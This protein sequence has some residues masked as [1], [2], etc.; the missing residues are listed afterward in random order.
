MLRLR[1]LSTAAALVFA[2]LQPQSLRAAPI[3]A[4]DTPATPFRVNQIT[5]GEQ[6]YPVV[7]R[8]PDGRFVIAWESEVDDRGASDIFAR[9][10]AADG[11]PLGPQFRVNRFRA[12]RQVFPAIAINASGAFVIAWQSNGQD[13]LALNAY[14]QRYAA[15]G[16]PVD[17]EFRVNNGVRDILVKVSV[18]LDDA[19]NA[20]FVWP[21]RDSP[22]PVFGSVRRVNISARVF[23]PSNAVSVAQFSVFESTPSNL[24]LPTVGVDARGDFVVVWQATVRQSVPLDG[25]DGTGAQSGGGIFGRRYTADGRARGAAFQIDTPPPTS[26]GLLRLFAVDQAPTEFSDR[27]ALLVAPGGD[28]V[29]A[30]QRNGFDFAALG[31][32]LRRYGPDGAPRAAETSFGAPLASLRAPVLAGT[33]DGGFIVAAHGAGIVAQRHGAGGAAITAPLRVDVDAAEAVLYP[34]IASDAEGDVVLVW[35]DY[36]QDGESRGIVARVCTLP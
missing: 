18:A 16:T 1:L 27:P 26:S 14:A 8:A 29:V 32:R 36:A 3:A 6:R 13:S 19:G 10:F 25:L 33:P 17:N 9:R 11:T 12:N 34:G 2:A 31:G 4:C 30:W 20:I 23:D 21:E 5:A 22:V 7:A 24:R 35:Q 15:D 28:F